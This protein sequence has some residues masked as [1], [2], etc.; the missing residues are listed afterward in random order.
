GAASAAVAAVCRSVRRVNREP[1]IEPPYL[2][3]AG[4]AAARHVS[5]PVPREPWRH[6]SAGCEGDLAP[7][8]A[9]EFPRCPIDRLVNRLAALGTMRDHLG[10][11]RLRENLVADPRWRWRSGDR[12]DHVTARRIV[13]ERALGW[14]LFLPGLKIVEFFEWGDI[15][16]MA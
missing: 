3:A 4:S 13:V 11:R 14:P 6:S 8:K 16:T 5:A 10:H 12:G 9:F 7:H 1:S 2:R 15:V